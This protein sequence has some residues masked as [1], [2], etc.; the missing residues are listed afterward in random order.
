MTLP[1]LAALVAG[2]VTIGFAPVLVRLSELGPTATAAMRMALSLPFFALL[3]WRSGWK[4]GR[5]APG[6]NRSWASLAVLAG[7]CFAGDLAFWHWS[8]TWTT[9]ANA[10]L[11]ANL[12]PLFVTL[13]GWWW[14]GER[15]TPGFLLGMLLALAGAIA[16]VGA[17]FG[18]S[19]DR[20]LGDLLGVA[21]A[22]FYAG[23]QLSVKR[24]AGRV[25]TSLLMGVSTLV[26]ALVLVP[27]AM[28]A[29]E[30][31]VPTTARGLGVLLALAIGPQVIGQGL[32]AWALREL[33]ASFSSVTLLVQPATAAL[34]G[35]L[36]FDERFGPWQWT[37]AVCLVAGI[38]L[39]R[40]ASVPG[41]PEAVEV[42][43]AR[44]VTPAGS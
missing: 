25:P 33:P 39:A 5:A 44:S 41:A 8:V 7:L 19:R 10:T 17:S 11:L 6:G 42:A 14:L 12:A 30:S 21:T 27:L 36:C 18:V 4:A 26:S 2:G 23:Y 1:P 32:I 43:G 37:G 38:G 29:G 3:A 34:L 15:I 13:A 35:W 31:L 24:V 28:A 16:L 40:R 9:V 20:L 22:F